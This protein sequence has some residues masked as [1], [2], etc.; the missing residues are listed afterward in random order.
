M[1]R[2]NNSRN[3]VK[4][5]KLLTKRKKRN[6]IKVKKIILINQIKVKYQNSLLRIWFKL[7]KIKNNNNFK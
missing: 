3:L 6:K 1:N 2:D 5:I 4:M 7:L